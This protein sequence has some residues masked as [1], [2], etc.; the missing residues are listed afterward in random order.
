MP[1]FRSASPPQP[2][3][4]PADWRPQRFGR[5]LRASPDT[6]VEP[7]WEGVR[8]IA[9][10]ENGRSHLIDADG[11]DCTSQFE[12]VSEALAAAARADE[13]ILDG[14]LTVQPTQVTAGIPES[15]VQV[16]TSGQM[17]AQMIVGARVVR[18]TVSERPIDPDRP[19]A[20]VAVDLLRI[21]G[22][23]LLDIPLLER[24]R[25][26]DGALEPNDLIR[27]TPFVR[28][29]CGAYITSWRGLGLQRLFWKDANS[30]YLPNARNDAWSDRPMPVK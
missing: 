23:T 30:R 1:P 2:P 12:A 3:T 24:K 11:R 27:I 29:P 26:L 6:I 18:P 21:D 10:Y 14:Y 15:S 22:T 9:R 8:V 19:V 20:F 5:G 25:L 17:M 7:G 28:E 13:L 16:P 4:N